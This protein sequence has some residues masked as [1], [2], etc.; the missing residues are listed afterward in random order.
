[1]A[2]LHQVQAD[3]AASL[4]DPGLT[5]LAARWLVGDTSHVKRRLEIYRANVAAS[6]SKALRAAYPIIAQVVGAHCFDEL[7]LDYAKHSPSTSGDLFDYGVQFDNLVSQHPGCR[8]LPYLPDL[9]RLEWAVH[10][11]YGASDGDAWCA[12]ELARVEPARQS[13]IRFE[14]TAGTAVFESRFP[15]VRVWQIHQMQYQ[16]E[17]TVD[18]S[19][20]QNALV[21]RDGFRIEVC[22]LDAGD[23]AFIRLS[24]GGG[25]LRDCVETALV[26]DASFD[27][28]RL[29]TRCVA[30]NWICG[31]NL[32]EDA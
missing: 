24:L 16:G 29:L 21:A 27:L 22:A 32:G 8:S 1:M 9:A 30:S 13:S 7:T 5:P 19:V 6:A 26:A 28:G 12:D 4:R 14:W 3:V 11:A 2:E 18:W 31:F 10:R 25:L 15:L 23:A 20:A 17:F